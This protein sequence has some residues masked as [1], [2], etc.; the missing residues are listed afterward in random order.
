MSKRVIVIGGGPAGMMAGGTAGSRGLEV[1]L[2]EKNNTLG[3]KLLL[4]GKGRCNFTND[5]DLQ[6]L[7]DNIPVNGRFLYSAFT[8]FSNKDL[9]RFF[10]SLGV[11]TKVERGGRVFPESDRAKDILDALERYLR[12]N[13]VKIIKGE[14]KRVLKDSSRVIGVTLSD[15]RF[16][17]S[18]SVIIATGGLSYP[19]TG[20]TGDGYEF[21]RELGHSIVTP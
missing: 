13:N 19:E 8:K 10:N 17:P 20:S 3:K 11:K 6:G 7:I 16:I 18:D 1:L 14:I 5:T 2:I 15:G 21:A 4:T 9:I 12:S